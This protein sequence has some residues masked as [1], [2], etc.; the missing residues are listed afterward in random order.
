MSAS[1]SPPAAAPARGPGAARMPGPLTLPLGGW[2]L[3]G[4]DMLRDPAAHFM[5]AYQRYG[6]I[7][8]WEPRRPRHILA[9][10]VEANRQVLGAPDTFI[11]DAFREANLPIGTSM[12]R[13]SFGLLRLNGDEHR[14]QRALMQPSFAARRVE[15][16]RDAVVAATEVALR[17]W[18][19]GQRRQLDEDIFR[20]I[21][22]IAM[23]TMFGLD[24]GS[25]GERL[26]RAIER[27][28]AVA[29]SPLTLLL[30]LDLPGTPYR[31]MLHTARRIE[32]ILLGLVQAK[33]AGG[34]SGPRD[35]LSDLIAARDDQGG[36]LSED[37]LVGQAYNVLCHSGSAAS[38]TWTLMLLDQHPAVLR[39]LVDELRQVLRGDAPT[40]EELG[41]L[42]YL[43]CVLKESLRLFP[44]AAFLLRYAAMDCQL[45][46]Y[47]VPK[48]ATVFVSPYVSHRLPEVFSAPLR[49]DPSR[50]Q[51]GTRPA[52][53]YHPYGLG[54]HNC[55]GRHVAQLEM[56]VILAMLLQR[57]RPALPAGT[58]LDR[59]MHISMVP[60]Q[61]LPVVLHGADDAVEPH[62]V[63]GNVL[64]HLELGPEVHRG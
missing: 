63:T 50:W 21:A 25:D 40:V 41:K 26:A 4:L 58:R 54:P 23:T 45:G 1:S 36:Q 11:V 44:P 57:F 48:D 46:D 49:F 47:A 22:G 32:D 59:R 5:R 34:G 53:E 8:T 29:S 16:Y 2:Q 10:G 56:K 61:G 24:A 62:R 13:L 17:T 51:S 35:V 7:S 30:R 20:L 28:L 60:K 37:E 52:H 18:K 64:D 6:A 55:L 3:H 38:L 31:A 42:E 14:R 27:L 15:H 33:R 19:V 12:S 43:E 39:T 9:L